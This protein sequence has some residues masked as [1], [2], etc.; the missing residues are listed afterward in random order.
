MNLHSIVYQ[1]ARVDLNIYGGILIYVHTS[2]VF[3][4]L[5]V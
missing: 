2:L 5:H 4:A 1:L 3:D